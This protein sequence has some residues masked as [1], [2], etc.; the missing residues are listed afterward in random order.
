MTPEQGAASGYSAGL[1]RRAVSRRPT[2]PATPNKQ[3]ASAVGS[4]Q[5]GFLVYL[6]R[7]S[8]SGGQLYTN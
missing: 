1:L 6:Q 3:I 7:T 4:T 5:A 8:E 2:A